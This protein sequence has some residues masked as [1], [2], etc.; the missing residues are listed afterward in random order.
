MR[1]ALGNAGQK[2]QLLSVSRC[3]LPCQGLAISRRNNV[4]LAPPWDYDIQFSKKWTHIRVYFD[5]YAAY[6]I[7]RS[8][9][10]RLLPCFCQKYD[11]TWS[12]KECSSSLHHPDWDLE[13]K[14][15][16]IPCTLPSKGT[17]PEN[18]EKGRKDES[19]F[20]SL[21]ECPCNSK[22]YIGALLYF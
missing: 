2:I 16:Y 3:N 19:E 1:K 18:T 21:L 7:H 5:Y 6:E 10:I 20:C 4:A 17:K 22:V 11:Y 8:Y 13:M 12:L 14:M 15:V 9:D